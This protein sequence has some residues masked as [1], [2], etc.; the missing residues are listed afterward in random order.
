VN[1]KGK[2]AIIVRSLQPGIEREADRVIVQSL[3]LTF[4]SREQRWVVHPQAEVSSKRKVIMPREITGSLDASSLRIAIVVTRWNEFIVSRLLEGA[5]DCIRMHSGALEDVT[6]VRCPGAFELPV[7]VRRLALSG[8]FDAIVALGAVIRGATPHFDYVAGA[9]TNGIA[10]ISLETS[11]PV[12]FGLLTVDT[13]EQA[14]ERAGT[15]GGNKG[16]ESALAAIETAR[17]LRAIDSHE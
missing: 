2:A 4:K 14:I 11:V 10:R 7:V 5:L 9:A 13:V 1:S 6:I 16:W 17:V 15:K 8:A 3:S 12:G